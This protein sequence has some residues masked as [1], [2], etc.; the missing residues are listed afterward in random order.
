[1]FTNFYKQFIKKTVL[2]G[3]GISFAILGATTQAVAE[4]VPAGPI[5]NGAITQAVAEDVPAGPIWNND[6]AKVK[7]PVVAAA[8][9]GQWNGGWHTT[10]E[11]KESVCH[12][13]KG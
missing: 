8:V 2:L 9:G 1:M 5:W 10:I 13:S 12:I 11:G 7:C 4:D 6:D 3:L